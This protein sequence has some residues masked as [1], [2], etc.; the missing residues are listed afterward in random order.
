MVDFVVVK[1]DFNNKG[2]AY[3]FSD[4]SIEV[5]VTEEATPESALKKLGLILE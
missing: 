4:S 2:P 1:K 5:I 3:V